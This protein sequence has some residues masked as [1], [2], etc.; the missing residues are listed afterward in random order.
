MTHSL[1]LGP[2]ALRFTLRIALTVPVLLT[3]LISTFQPAEAQAAD[4]A[5][6]EIIVQAQ[7]RSERMVDVPLTM[8]NVTGDEMAKAGVDATAN[9][10]QIVPA[11]RIDY[12]GAF[13][14]P[15]IRGIS[16]ALANV[17]GGSAVGVYVDGFYNASPLTSDFELLNVSSIQVLKGPQG[18]LFGRNTTAGAVLV[19]TSDPS[20]EA[21][22][23][24]TLGYSRY[25]TVK[26]AFYGTT[27]LSDN[28]AVDLSLDYKAGDG[29]FENVSNGDDKIG[30]HTT[31]HARLGLKWEGENG[32]VKLRIIHDDRDDPISVNWS[33]YDDGGGRFQ[34]AAQTFGIP[35]AVWGREIGE[36]A[37]DPGFEPDYWSEIDAYQL[38][39]EYDLGFADLTS[40]T[41]YRDELS[42]HDIEVDN[43][44]IE[45]FRVSFHNFDEL[46]TQEFLLNS[47]ADSSFDWVVGAFYMN[48]KAGQSDFTIVTPA[49]GTM[50]ETFNEIDS[51]AVFADAT[52]QAG[53][54]L[55]VTAGGRYSYEENDGFWGCRP[56]GVLFGV[57]PPTT[58]VKDDWNDF[59]PRLSLRYDLTDYSSTYATISRGFKA[60]LINVNGFATQTIDPEQLL[61]YEVGYKMS[62]GTTRL[63]ASAFYYDYE[64]LQVSS[65]EGTR[66][67]TTNAATSE[68]YGA[69]LTVNHNVS[70]QLTVTFGLAVN[71]GRYDEYL[72]APANQYDYVLDGADTAGVPNGGA[73]D[74]SADN[75][76]VDVTGNNMI[77]SPDVT[78][79]LALDYNMPFAGGQ[80]N[81]YGNLYY[82]SKVYFDAA[83]NNEMDAFHQLNLRAIWMPND[84]QYT[85]AL[86]LN[87]AT[88][89]EVI[90]QVLPNGLGTGV[91]WSPPR[92]LGV[93]FTYGF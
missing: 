74:G 44:S 42:F 28:V 72:Q 26:A 9:L 50:Y 37:A 62:N 20:T 14:Q 64:D 19:N 30:E 84:A 27:G 77:R 89:E 2:I 58:N 33:V 32:S 13:A 45:M 47:K 25:D 24:T 1:N 29:F 41:Q 93:N 61:S 82:S 79:N 3:G 22:V 85:V 66:S 63:E 65:Y 11:F 80:L 21:S 55:F 69:E 4:G 34:T 54:K 5:M 8:S 90:T 92:T 36:L 15:T 78:G 59:S 23:K 7:R 71:H 10:G 91:S 40:Y 76:P 39:M 83:N 86:F 81:F 46:T 31:W 52:W 17:G 53:E 88:D 70:E 6:E 68:V 51:W 38:T 57:C 67:I 49:L 87:N 56:N 60:G 18:T 16:T 35:G 12:N 75:R 43:S 73:T 48:Q